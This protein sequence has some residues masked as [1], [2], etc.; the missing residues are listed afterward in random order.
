MMDNVTVFIVEDDEAAARSL[1]ALMMSI[2]FKAST[3]VSAEAF[4]DEYN[5]QPGCL[6]LDVRLPGMNGLELQTQLAERS[7]DIPIVFMSG[8]ADAA[9]AQRA[10]RDGAIAFLQKPFAFEELNSA[11]RKGLARIADFR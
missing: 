1:V 4:L 8:H 3:F 6:L 9:I 2:G 10:I 5:G 7:H 11:I